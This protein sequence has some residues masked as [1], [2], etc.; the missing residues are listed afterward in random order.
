MSSADPTAVNAVSMAGAAFA[1]NDQVFVYSQSAYLMQDAY[2]SGL[3]GRPFEPIQE[4]DIVNDICR[5]G[6]EL[7]NGSFAPWEAGNSVYM[8]GFYVFRRCEANQ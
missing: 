6:W 3:Y 4:V 8:V 7:V 1:R 2:A 5:Q